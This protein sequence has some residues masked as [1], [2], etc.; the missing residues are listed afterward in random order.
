MSESRQTHVTLH[1]I[2]PQALEQLVQYAYTAEIV[3]GEGNVQTLLP[4]AS[5]LQL[6]GVRDA[7]CKFLLSQLD[8]SNCLGIRGFA[9]THSCSD[10]LKSAHKYVLQ[11]FVEVAKTEEFMLL[12][13]KQVRCCWRG[14]GVSLVRLSQ[15]DTSP[16]S[17]LGAEGREHFSTCS[18]SVILWQAKRACWEQPGHL[19][20]S[21]EILK[22]RVRAESSA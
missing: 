12:P 2:D 11:H 14:E 19:A 3:V 15:R 13:L 5:L 21:H 4:A 20:P 17:V 7:C 16:P 1:D 8:P 22:G 9:D 6:N 10:L 18:S